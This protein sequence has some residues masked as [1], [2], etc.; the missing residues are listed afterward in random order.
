MKEY[1]G[2]LVLSQICVYVYLPVYSRGIKVNLIAIFVDLS[3]D[4]V[5]HERKAFSH[6]RLYE[7]LS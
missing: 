6:F 2:T 1:F 4:Y 5:P 3:W 7:T